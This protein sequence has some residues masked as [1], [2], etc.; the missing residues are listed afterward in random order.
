MNGSV[1]QVD[2]TLYCFY[3]QCLFHKEQLA[4]EPNRDSSFIESQIIRVQWG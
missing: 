1:R 4:R 2:E 3:N